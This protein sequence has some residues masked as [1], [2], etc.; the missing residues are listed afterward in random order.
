[1]SH[2]PESK[3]KTASR[4]QHGVLATVLV[5][6]VIV[7]LAALMFATDSRTAS[8]LGNTLRLAGATSLI[9]IPVGTFL[10]FALLRT[11]MVGRPLIVV[12]LATMLFV[13]LYLQAAGCDAGFGRQGWLSLSQGTLAAPLLTGWRAVIWIHSIASVPWVVLIVGIRLR[14]AEPDLEDAALLD[15]SAAQVL[16]RITLRRAMPAVLVAAL[17]IVITTAGEITVTDLYQV[18]T[19]AEEIYSNVP[20][21]GEFGIHGLAALPGMLLVTGLTLVALFTASS[22]LPP[23]HVTLPAEQR[24]I[25][26]GRWRW[27]TSGVVLLVVVLIAGLP[28]LNLCINAGMTVG[29]MEG[30]PFRF[31]SETKF[32]RI[33]MASPF[34]FLDEFRW[35]NVIGNVVGLAAVALAGPLAWVARQ[36]AGRSW[37]VL[38]PIA[39]CL[40]LPGPI[41]GLSV[42]WLLNRDA[43]P[44]LIWLYDHTILAPC[45]ATLVRA[46]PIA[47]L[48]TWFSLRTVSADVL[49]AASADGA[50]GLARMI[51][52]AIPQRKMAIVV[53]WFAAV[54]IATGDLSAS[55]LVT[56]PGVSTIP[57][58]VFGLLHAGVDDQ[59]AGLCLAM[60]G[61]FVILAA[62]TITIIRAAENRVRAQR[63]SRV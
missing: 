13:P 53:A 54:V 18:R 32:V 12:V 14:Y 59:V 35:T 17:W 39:A 41:I 50:G 45:L 26:L 15:A 31:W 27:V 55:I 22:I 52:I 62:V 42:I 46:F 48:I 3:H 28:L 9:A 61:E 38:L 5:A 63:H 58:R 24:V 19:Y 33:V 6:G 43:S 49:D 8:L 30:Q 7:L 57:I 10:A 21:Y 20:S 34:E 1:M 36:R 16:F 51:H 25:P 47:M 40:A 11:N 60:V 29:Y 23:A 44:L 56:P 4:P 37:L 2:H